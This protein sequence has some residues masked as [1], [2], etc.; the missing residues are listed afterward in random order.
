MT[1]TPEIIRLQRS[2]GTS[3]ALQVYAAADP[4]VP[5]ILIQPAMGVKAGYYT[6]L[7]AALQEAG[8]NVAVAELRGHEES[9][10]RKPGHDYDFGYH[11]LLTEDW[12]Q[13]VAAVKAHFPGAPLYLYG[14]SLGGQIS[15]IYAAHNPQQLDGLILTA[16][17]S[18]HWKLWPLPFWPYSQAAVLV[19]KLLG[20]FPGE[21]FRFA[22]REARSVIADWGRQARTGRFWFGKPE[23]TDHDEVLATMTIPV[24]AISLQ[25]D[26]FA[27]RHAM[28]DIVRRFP[29][30]ALTRQHLDPKA[31]GIDGIDHFRWVRKP[32]V[33]LPTLLD[34]LNNR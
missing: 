33:V 4:L 29:K 13:S 6:P 8:Y 21:K 25:G 2:E 15:A 18:V 10:G 11:E 16:V 9:G 3:F 30:A 20:H 24:L 28:D 19:A 34:W 31:M 26:F 12:P 1:N 22:G 23:R 7:A 5:V 27:P 32:Q 17:S 14:H